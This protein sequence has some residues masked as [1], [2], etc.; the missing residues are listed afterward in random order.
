[1]TH[2]LDFAGCI[3]WYNLAYSSILYIAYKV[4]FS[5]RAEFLNLDIIS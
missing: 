3:L 2:S 1:M 5:P 4:V